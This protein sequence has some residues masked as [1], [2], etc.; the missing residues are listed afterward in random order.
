[1]RA[2][3]TAIRD[4]VCAFNLTALTRNLKMTKG[5]RMHVAAD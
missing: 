1:M 5:E 2:V 4:E 3:A